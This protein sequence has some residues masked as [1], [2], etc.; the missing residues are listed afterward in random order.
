MSA[1]YHRQWLLALGALLGYA[2]LM[3]TNG[4][5]PSLVDG[6]RALRRYPRLWGIPAAL[7]L[8][9]ALFHAA[10]TLFFYKVLP[11]EQQPA[12][13]WKFSWFIPPS[14][15]GETHTLRDWL[16][17][18]F[19]DP[20]WEVLRVAALQGIE[21]LAGLFNN[22]VT[23]FPVSAVAGVLL[24]LNWDDHHSTLR[25]ALRKRF[26][27]EAW[28]AHLGILTCAVSA[29]IE[30][31]LFGPSLIYFDRV[32]PGL[33]LVRWSVL[34]DWLSSLFAYLFGAGV[35]VYLILVVYTWLRGLTWTPVHLMDMAIRRFSFVVKWAAV[36]VACSSLAIDVPRICAL[37]FRFG[38][39]DFFDHTLAYTDHIARPL[40][41]VFLILF[42]T[43]Q[44]TLTF[45]SE[46]LRKALTQHWEFLRRHGGKFL[47]FL[48]IAGIHLFGLAFL[49]RWLLFGFGESGFAG[50]ETTLAGLAW[51]F[52]YPLIAAFLAAWLL[53][54]WVSL[55]K[56][57]ETGRPQLP[58]QELFPF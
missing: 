20:R 12:F 13:D 8:C 49:N 25:T 1:A 58:E 2:V 46:T 57:C 52:I 21:S 22:V 55:Y 36:V 37:L 39:Q 42:A 48:L 54:S 34:I 3:W 51:S 56:R 15:L 14:H 38:D 27:G 50:L 47:W 53:S 41:A 45:H 10:L 26:G 5:R 19:A 17:V 44:V 40:L 33:L 35:Q 18:F 29:I 43:M 23:T 4:V 30:P 32:A 24:L 9:Y 6:M 28:L 11:I 7:G 16:G 31:V